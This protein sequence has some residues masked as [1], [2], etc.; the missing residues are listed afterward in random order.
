MRELREREDHHTIAWQDRGDKTDRKSSLC[1]RRRAAYARSCATNDRAAHC[2]RHRGRAGL[3]RGATG[4]SK[5]PIFVW[6]GDQNPPRLAFGVR[7]ERRVHRCA[8]RDLL[9]GPSPCPSPTA[10]PCRRS[11][12]RAAR[13]RTR[14]NAAATAAAV[15]CTPGGDDG[16]PGVSGA[17][18]DHQLGGNL[19]CAREPNK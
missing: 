16:G 11:S 19:P 9:A 4:A 8:H 12:Q 7:P 1:G 3:A 18:G 15:G 17:A 10:S 2:S 6:V 5:Q 13:P 14:Q